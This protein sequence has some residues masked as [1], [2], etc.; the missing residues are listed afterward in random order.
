L[1]PSASKALHSK[2]TVKKLAESE[3]N[4]FPDQSIPA[5]FVLYKRGIKT[6]GTGR[7]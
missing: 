1:H 6:D 2:I 4:L 3:M 7:K 5:K